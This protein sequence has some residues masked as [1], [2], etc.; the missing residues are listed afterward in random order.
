M[1]YPFFKKTTLIVTSALAA[2]ALHAQET[3]EV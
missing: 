1:I 3:D 2:A